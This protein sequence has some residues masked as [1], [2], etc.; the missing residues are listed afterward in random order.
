MM[1]G[2]WFDSLF[3]QN[4]TEEHLLDVAAGALSKA[5]GWSSPPRHYRAVVKVQRKCIAQYTVGHAARVNEARQLA[6]NSG[7]GLVG[8]SYDGVG[9]ND[10]IMS[11][12]RWVEDQC[13]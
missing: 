7:M 3:G 12:K 4:P 10:S 11:A 5:L 8:A 1:G 13:K 6:G 2:A 9:I